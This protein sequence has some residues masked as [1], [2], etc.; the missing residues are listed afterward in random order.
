MYQFNELYPQWTQFA[1]LRHT[2]DP[3][4]LFCNAFIDSLFPPNHDGV[5]TTS[6]TRTPSADVVVFRAPSKL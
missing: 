4:R 1:A 5:E 3:H 6:V 2:V